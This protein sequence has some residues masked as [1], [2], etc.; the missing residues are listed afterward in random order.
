[1]FSGPLFSNA[2]LP[3]SQDIQETAFVQHARVTLDST[4][5]VQWSQMSFF[6]TQDHEVTI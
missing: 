6:S 3:L 5:S 4:L 1:M 2:E